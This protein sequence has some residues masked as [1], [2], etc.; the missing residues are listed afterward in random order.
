MKICIVCLIYSLLVCCVNKPN[1]GNSG[2]ENNSHDEGIMRAKEDLSK[3]IIGYYFY[4]I[5]VPPYAD[6]LEK[7]YGVVVHKEGCSI[8]GFEP[9]YDSVMRDAMIKRFGMDI[10]SELKKNKVL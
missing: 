4:G 10:I 6:T 1:N 8:S 9:A 3:G 7:K 5:A 2:I